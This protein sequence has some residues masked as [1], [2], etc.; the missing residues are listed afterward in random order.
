MKQIPAIKSVMTPFPH[1]V[2]V[3]A[4]I[5]EAKKFMLD[6]R[7]HHLPVTDN[8]QLVGVLSDR[9]IKLFLGPDFD[10]PNEDEVVV[11]DVYMDHPYIVDLNERL[12]RVLLTMAEKH[13]GSALVTRHGKLAGVFT[14]TD[15][16][17]S[18][19]EHLH[20]QFGPTS[21]NDAA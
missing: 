11:K 12:D 20:N 8:E 14:S 7:I 13:I 10:Y 3:D 17:K 1:S 5:K 2:S 21:G 6:H 4:P 15:A 19:A 16:C 18:F 9:D